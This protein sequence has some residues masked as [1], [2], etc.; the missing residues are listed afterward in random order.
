MGKGVPPVSLLRPHLAQA[1]HVNKINKIVYIEIN[2]L[3]NKIKKG[4]MNKYSSERLLDSWVEGEI[5]IMTG[6]AS[7]LSMFDDER[8][9]QGKLTKIEIIDNISITWAK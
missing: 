8:A 9:V 7:G 2:I 4:K 3:L 6:L 1:P 5:G